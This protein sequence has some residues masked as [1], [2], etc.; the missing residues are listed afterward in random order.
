MSNNVL[1]RVSKVV[2]EALG[3]T[4][5][6]V[7]TDASFKED[8]GADSLD[9]VEM[10]MNLEEEFGVDIPDSDVANLTTVGAVVSYIEEK[11]K[12]SAE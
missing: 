12:A 1:E 4:E 3:V 5:S 9:V 10:V 6:E 7:V 8:L 2:C 11:S